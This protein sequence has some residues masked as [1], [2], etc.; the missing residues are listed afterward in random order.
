VC[1]PTSIT[2]A[3]IRILI[4]QIEIGVGRG[5]FADIRETAAARSHERA[6]A[7]IGLPSSEWQVI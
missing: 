2:P 3:S 7:I 6:T 4:Y 1:S 5:P